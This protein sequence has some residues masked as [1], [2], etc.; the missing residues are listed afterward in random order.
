MT[1]VILLAVLVLFDAGLAGFRAAAGRDGRIEKRTYFRAAIGR[2]FAGAVGLLAVNAALV[3][4]LV[5]T[6]SSSDETWGTLTHAAELCV[7]IFGAFATLTLAAFAFWF[8]PVEEYRLLSTVIVLGPLTLIR[9]VIIIGG[10]A[11]V[12]MSLPEPRVIVAAAFACI[13]MLSF[14]HLVGRSHAERWRRLV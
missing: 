10:L 6:A 11:A 4:V 12:C 2:S 13:S 5:L 14:E 8:S 7:W 3:A 9:P 1:A